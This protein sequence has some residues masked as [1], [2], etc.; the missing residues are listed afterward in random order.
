MPH[1]LSAGQAK[2]R[3]STEPGEKAEGGKKDFSAMLADDLEATY[4]LIDLPRLRQ[5]R[6][7]AGVSPSIQGEPRR[8]A[9]HALLHPRRRVYTQVPEFTLLYETLPKKLRV[10]RID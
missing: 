10:Y 2:N 5:A 3:A 7:V 1:S 4:L 6:Y 8:S 9:A